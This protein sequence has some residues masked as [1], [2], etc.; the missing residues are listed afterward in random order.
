MAHRG[1]GQKSLRRGTAVIGMAPD[2]DPAS[3]DHSELDKYGLGS[4]REL[5][6]FYRLFLIDAQKRSAVQL[7]PF[8]KS[9]LMHRNFQKYIRA[10]R[11]GID[12]SK[13]ADFDTRKFL[14]NQKADPF[15]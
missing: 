6:L 2:L 14:P 8:V 4:V 10:D 1:E 11:L 3:W 13:L 15:S 9:G 7:C 5:S 12:Y